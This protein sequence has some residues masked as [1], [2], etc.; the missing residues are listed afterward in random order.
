MQ[1]EKPRKILTSLHF[2]RLGSQF[3]YHLGAHFCK[4]KAMGRGRRLWQIEGIEVPAGPGSDFSVVFHPS[5]AA[6]VLASSGMSRYYL[7][8]YSH[9]LSAHLPCYGH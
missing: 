7:A 8:L 4:A 2:Q 5:R 6:D 3:L 1:S 9:I